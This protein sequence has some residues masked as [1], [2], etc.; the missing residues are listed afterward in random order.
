MNVTNIK[1]LEYFANKK[2]SDYTKQDW[3]DLQKVSMAY[4]HLMRFIKLMR[5]ILNKSND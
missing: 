2:R 3:Q 1:D 4:E 5:I